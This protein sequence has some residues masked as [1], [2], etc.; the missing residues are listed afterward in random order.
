MT[1]GTAGRVPAALALAVAAISFAAIF[2]RLADTPPLVAAGVRLLFSAL[3]LLPWTLRGLRAGRLRGA[4]GRAGAL[5]GLCYAVHFSSW[6][7]S[8]QRTTIAASVTLVTA[9]PIVLALHG[10]ITGRD[11]PTRTLLGALG[12]GAVGVAILGGADLGRGS[13]ALL[14]DGFA[15]L[16]CAA[17]A[18]YLLVARRLGPDLDVLGFAGIATG[19]GA[20][21]LLAAAAAAGTP[22][23]PPSAAAAGWLLLSALVPQL[24]G[25][26]LL[27]W[28]LRH[29]TPTAVGTA[30]LGEP[31]GA[32]LLGWLVLGESVG[33]VAA[34]GCAVT[35]AAVALALRGR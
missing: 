20:V 31:V 21:A 27:T 26:T 25:H 15:L 4:V 19:V 10:L 34:A 30:T 1:E 29:A 16:G 3:L 18:A 13:E 12:L 32:S 33:P 7:A 5:G 24:I 35:L 6:V 9:T 23:L 2:F 14:G 28:S 22:P 17:M 11:R 8:L